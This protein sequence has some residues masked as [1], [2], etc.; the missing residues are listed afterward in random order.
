MGKAYFVY[1]ATN[2]R[3]TVLYTGVTSTIYKRMFEH[4]NKM[5]PSFTSKYNVNK[6]VWGESFGTPIEAISAEKR[7]KGWTRVK[8]IALIEKTN[9]QWNDLLALDRDSSLHSE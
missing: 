2:K 4:K 8:K 1:I 7:I 3:N 6:L 5:T 9:P